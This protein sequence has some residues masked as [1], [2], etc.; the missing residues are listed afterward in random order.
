MNV[1]PDTT[2]HDPQDSRDAVE[3]RVCANNKMIRAEFARAEKIDQLF[4]DR[5]S[6]GAFLRGLR[7]D[8]PGSADWMKSPAWLANAGHFLAGMSVLLVAWTFT[9][10]SWHLAAVWCALVAYAVTKEYWFDLHYE[11]GED[12]LS[13]TVDLVGYVLGAGAATGIIEI[14]RAIG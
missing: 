5:G 4:K 13:S 3:V 11:S 14:A 2:L 9:H 10:T 6:L 1:D 8:K 12:V 7:G